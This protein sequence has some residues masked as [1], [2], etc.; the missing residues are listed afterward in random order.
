MTKPFKGN[1]KASTSIGINA[2]AKTVWEILADFSAV[3]TW[4]PLVLSSHVEFPA[5]TDDK[6]GTIGVGTIRHC[7]I[8]KLGKIN[9]RI[10]EWDDG[11]IVAYQISTLGPMKAMINRWRV[12]S[13]GE[14]T[15]RV[16]VN[17]EY[18]V[19]F[20][21]LGRIANALFLGR[22]LKKQ[23]RKGAVLLL[24]ERAETGKLI[25]PRRAPDGQPQLVPVTA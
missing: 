5:N 14:N 8:N 9:E 21:F 16:F 18:T 10:L 15:S 4:V 25:R 12:E 7:E 3:D 22:L 24:K 2:S 13:T 1:H 17:L 20:G 19:R 23:M 6:T 11:H